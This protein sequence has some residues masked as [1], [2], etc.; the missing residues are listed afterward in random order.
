ME[1]YIRKSE[2]KAEIERLEKINQEYKKTWK[3]KFKWFYRRIIGR[4][5]VLEG[6]K[7]FLN[8]LEV[9]DH[10]EQNSIRAGIY[11]YAS[12]YSCC[13]QSELFNQ[14][15]KEQQFLWYK[16]IKQAVINGGNAGAK[17]A[18]DILYNNQ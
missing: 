6:L 16:E 5:E 9:K 12:T 13:M 14:L 8:V 1:E 7:N 10:Y 15:T 11:A 3:W 2:V 17:L 4:L 18:E